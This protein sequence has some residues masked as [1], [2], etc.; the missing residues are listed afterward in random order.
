MDNI[1]I[2]T[3]HSGVVLEGVS[4]PS[5]APVAVSGVAITI[6][7]A[8]VKPDSRP[9]VTLIKR[10]RPVVPAPP[11]RGPKQTYCRRCN[12]GAR[13]PIII[14]DIITIT[15][16]TGSP[17][18][19]GNRAGRLL[20]Y[21]QNRRSKIDRYAY[22]GVRGRQRHANKSSQNK[23]TQFSHFHVLMVNQS[24]INKVAKKN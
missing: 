7:D 15:P 16:V 23:G 4:L 19:T 6:V 10:V 3:R 2:H 14:P 8:A 12:P 24:W 11:R 22:L 13:H 20:I 1:V 18:I 17:D 9:P 21:R 5:S